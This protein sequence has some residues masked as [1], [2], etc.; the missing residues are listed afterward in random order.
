MKPVAAQSAIRVMP[1]DRKGMSQMPLVVAL[2]YYLGA[3]AAFLI[4]T[5]S[6]NIFAPFWPPN[7][8]LFCALML[9]P[10]KRWWLFILAVLPAH[11]FAELRVGMPVSQL[12]VA[13]VTNVLVA[14]VNAF[15]LQCLVAGPKW[16]D[17]LRKAFAYVVIAASAS[18]MVVALGGAFMP[19]I[20]NAP[21]EK[22]WVFWTQ[23]YLSNALGFLT[24]G[25]VALLLLTEGRRFL[26]PLSLRRTLEALGIAAALMAV[27]IIAF[28]AEVTIVSGFFPTLIYLPLPLVLLATMRFGIH[29]ASSTILIVTVVLI[30]Q[31]L[32]GP[33]LFDTGDPE[34]SVFAMQAFL[35]GLS[36]PILLLGAAIDE[37]RQA[38]QDV[39]QSEESMALAAVSADMCLWKFDTAA[40]QFWITEHGRHMLGLNP[41]GPITRAMIFDAIHQDDRDI[42]VVALQNS[43]S[44]KSVVDAEFRVIHPGGEVR[45]IRSRTRARPADHSDGPVQISGT[46]SDV[47][48]QKVTETEIAQQRQ[49][50]AHLMRV[51]MLG[52]LSGGIA[53][54]LTQ[55][56]SAIRS[57][58]ET[59]RILLSR[60]SFAIDEL[61]DVLDD[62]IEEDHR[63]G[64]V[65]HRIRG[66]LTKS[67]MKFEQVEINELTRSTLR[68][69]NSE[70]ISRRV[71]TTLRLASELPMVNGDF[72]QLQQV[73]LNLLMNAMD[74]MTDVPPARRMM[75]V[76]TR[77]I[78]DGD[79]EV[80][81]SD[82]GVGLTPAQHER[83]LQPFFT[84]KPQ[85]LGLGLSLCHSIVKLH[86]GTLTLNNNADGGV[87]ALFA[88]RQIA[89]EGGPQKVAS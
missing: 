86:G 30:W 45:W 18:P 32:K 34:N 54:E 22:Y 58:A 80:V 27:C 69:L 31:T 37:A 62:I 70:L 65:I 56:L 48:E 10:R 61:N 72:I 64:E 82:C 47:T 49:E 38:E 12:L 1:L 68:L 36:A 8:V 59:A 89:V 21:I 79:V 16:F 28:R 4:G 25:P 2:A 87:T 19:I 29:G 84:T 13:F 75:T 55:P 66:L 88:L 44:S 85:G 41:H 60:S 40:E 35:I 77:H 53:H 7:I 9:A 11:T 71:K 43:I 50:I 39:R 15:A 81:V 20:G 76:V 78:G 6:D 5:L 63:A 83:A 52:E 73:I 14:A 17:S 57:N 74:A 24:L 33:A 3:E 51:S 67:E 42:A 26:S 46:F 23:W